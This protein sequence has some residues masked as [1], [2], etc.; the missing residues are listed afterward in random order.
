MEKERLEKERKEKEQEKWDKIKQRFEFRYS[1]HL[2][3]TKDLQIGGNKKGELKVAS[4]NMLNPTY[5]CA[6]YDDHVSKIE[7]L[8][9]IINEKNGCVGHVPKIKKVVEYLIENNYD[10]I[11]L[12]E[13]LPRLPWILPELQKKGYISVKVAKNCDV[14]CQIFA[15]LKNRFEFA[16]DNKYR[17]FPHPNNDKYL[18]PIVLQIT[19]T[20]DKFIFANI[21]C[22]QEQKNT[23]VIKKIIAEK[24]NLLT[25]KNYPV[26]MCGDFNMIYPNK[27]PNNPN[28]QSVE[29]YIAQPF[30]N[31]NY[32]L[33]EQST[34]DNGDVSVLIM[35]EDDSIRQ[36]KRKYT[37]ISGN[38]NPVIYDHILHFVPEPEKEKDQGGGNRK[39]KIVT[40]NHQTNSGNFNQSGGY[41]IDN[42]NN[43]DYREK[44]LKY[45]HKYQNHENYQNNRRN[46]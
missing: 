24:I 39:Y 37:H 20:N 44:Y 32:K 12:Q 42:I 34:D 9:G 30:K 21:H 17:R 8:E 23:Q 16:S 29:T 43:I 35:G 6:H 26:I 5:A 3:I 33:K 10:L 28:W 38:L 40:K 31:N 46:N 14:N 2:A 19:G 18:Q 22:P 25:S 11:A 7:G 13:V 36:D 41:P 27:R 4:L 1:D 45:K 15:F